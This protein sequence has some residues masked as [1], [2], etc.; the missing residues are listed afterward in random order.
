[1]NARHVAVI[2]SACDVAAHKAA[3]ILRPVL[4]KATVLLHFNIVQHLSLNILSVGCSW[5]TSLEAY[6]M[7]YPFHHVLTPY[8]PSLLRHSLR[9]KAQETLSIKICVDSY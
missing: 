5:S 3:F 6:G 1:M 8:P 4:Y 2:P 9:S 7:Q